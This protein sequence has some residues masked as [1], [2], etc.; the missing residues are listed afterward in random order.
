MIYLHSTSHARYQIQSPVLD[1][2][3]RQML[4]IR[5][6]KNVHYTSCLVIEN[7]NKECQYPF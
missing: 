7:G 5:F 1:Y 6:S 2:D 4:L 3:A